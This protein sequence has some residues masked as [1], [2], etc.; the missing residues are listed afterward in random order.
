[1]VKILDRYVFI[2]VARY[3]FLSLVTF[4]VLFVVID[5]VSKIDSLL[6]SGIT[7]GFL[8]VTYR[9]PLY[10]VRVIPI[11]T[12]IATMVTLANFSS[13]SELIVVKSLGISLYR[14]SLPIL[15]FALLSSVVSCL[16]NELVIPRSIPLAKEIQYKVK[17]KRNLHISGNSVWFKKS[18]DLFVFMKQIDTRTFEAKRISIFFL[19][20]EFSP[21]KRID[22]FYGINIKDGI[23]KLKDCFERDLL[24]LRVK[25]YPEKEINLGI[26]KKDLV[27][28]RI[29]PEIMNSISLYR[30]IRQL[31]KVG[32]DVRSY[33][34][35]LYSKF[36]ISLL[37]L[38][39][40]VIGI[41]LG[42]FNPRNRK[43]YT[44]VIAAVLIVLMWI[45]ISFFTSLGK[46]GLLPP[47]YA[48][49]APEF[50][51]LSIGL[52]LLSRMET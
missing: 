3:F 17:K 42:V 11:A 6:K 44:L 37:P 38:I 36:A 46:S 52:I 1:M 27:L 15:F 29:E 23:W 31:E 51:F 7:D 14:F 22:A 4:I 28:T 21:V 32:Y 18:S 45:T 19:G 41:P 20:K 47:L 34:V 33:L 26:G 13:S 16:I 2:E 30:V 49:F 12:L 48:A 50:M 39:V 8:Y 35:E 25:S 43:G 10:M 9:I 24:N 5:F 40:A